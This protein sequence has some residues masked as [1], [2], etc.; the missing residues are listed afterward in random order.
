MKEFVADYQK[1]YPGMAIQVPGNVYYNG[2]MA[3]RELL[4]CVEEAGTT[5]NIA[6]IKKLEAR[7][8]SARDRMQDYDAWIDPATHQCQQTIYM[9]TYNDQP[10]AKDDIFKIL[11]KVPPKDVEDPD[12]PE[13][14]QARNLRRHA[15]V[16]DV[17]RRRA[18]GPWNSLTN[19]VPHLVNGV[20]LGLLFALI[21]LGFMLIVSVMET[22]N[23][24]HGSFFALGMYV[25]LFVIAPKLGAF[26]ALAEWYG[27]LPL[28][29]ALC[30]RAA[31]GAGRRRAS[32]ACCWSSRCAAPTAAIRS[33]AC[34]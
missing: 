20:A 8:V 18:A 21:A 29:M 15:D 32:S 12:A 25:A 2:Y 6:V 19:L 24:A 33:T 4:R 34:C 10:E 17:S 30:A 11:T 23:L 14:V 1:V 7:K 31:A 9:A 22:I 27:A 28:G 13:D 26:P 5:N 16:R 3:T